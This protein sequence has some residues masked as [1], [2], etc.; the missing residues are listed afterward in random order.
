VHVLD[1]PAGFSDRARDLLT[2]TGRREPGPLARTPTDFL[3]VP[4]ASGRLIPA[5]T[6][7]VVGREHFQARFGRLRYEVSRSALIGAERHDVT[8]LWDFDLG[9]GIW[10]DGLGWSFEWTGEHVSSPVRFLVH[11]DGRVGVSDGGPFIDIAPSVPHLI[12]SHAIMDMVS[13]WDP[14]PGSLEPWAAN[15]AGVA[16]AD[17]VEGLAVVTEASGPS[18]TWLL[19]DHVAIRSFRVWTSRR[20]RARA[21][22]I[23]TRGVEGR[24]QLHHAAS[25][26]TW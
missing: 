13:S 16:L 2:R 3:R 25:R 9:A 7:L 6:K 1:D 15:G 4:D 14:Q 17:R 18:E 23:W 8:R 12:E 22:Q 26:D 11:T 20:P 21:V 19:C 24:R 10:A 5:P